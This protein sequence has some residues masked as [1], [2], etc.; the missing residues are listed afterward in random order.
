ML[1][2]CQDDI[3]VFKL[4]I[5][6]DALETYLISK[7]FPEEEE[8]IDR[9]NSFLFAWSQTLMKFRRFFHAYWIIPDN[10]AV[11][12]ISEQNL[13]QPLFTL[14]LNGI[15]EETGAKVKSVDSRGIKLLMSLLVPDSEGEDVILTLKGYADMMLFESEETETNA[16]ACLSVI[17]LKSP[18]RVG[19]LFASSSLSSKDQLLG[20][21]FTVADMKHLHHYSLSLTAPPTPPALP[22]RTERTTE[23]AVSVEMSHLTVNEPTDALEYINKSP[24]SKLATFGALTDMFAL[25]IMF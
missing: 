19:A 25:N 22:N 7:L 8:G 21:V 11:K 24:S 5:E 3:K 20:E 9:L 14:F 15:L 16:E 10:S 18:M 1:I 6:S 17:E 4:D 12:P 13:L 23:M 2:G